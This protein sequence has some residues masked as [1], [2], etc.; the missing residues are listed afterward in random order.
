MNKQLT[1][2]IK[3]ECANYFTGSSNKKTYCCLEKYDNNQCIY[4]TNEENPR[5][6]YFEHCV[7]L[8]NPEMELLYYRQLGDGAVP[9]SASVTATT[10]TCQRCGKSIVVRSRRQKYCDLC[11][12]M[13]RRERAMQKIKI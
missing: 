2:F 3:N 1:Q 11:K 12:K 9:T 7:L 8:L 4:F 6:T 10:T 13:I 5:C